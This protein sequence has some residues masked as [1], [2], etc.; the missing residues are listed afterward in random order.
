ME[1]QLLAN[2]AFRV[3]FENTGFEFK[4]S[5]VQEAFDSFTDIAA[6][7]GLAWLID[8]TSDCGMTHLGWCEWMAQARIELQKQ[9]TE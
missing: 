5:T 8:S 1:L 3:I 7:N 6:S 9:R 2:E 4:H